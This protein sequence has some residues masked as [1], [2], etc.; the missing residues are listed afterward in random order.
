[1]ATTTVLTEEGTSNFAQAG[2]LNVHYNEAG[3]GDTVVMLHGGGPGASGWSNYVT[4]F[5][6]FSE[7]YRAILMDM[8]GYGKSDP[9]EMHE[10]YR[11]RINALAL[12]D[13]LDTLG[14][15]KANV[16]GNSMG[17]AT[18]A[19][20][21]IAYPERINKLVLMGAGGGGA[22][23]MQPMPLE[24][25][26]RI[27]ALFEDPTLEGFRE[28]IKIFVY[29]S[30]FMTDDLLHQRL[31]NTLAHPE[32]LEARRKSSKQLED[33]SPELSKIQADTLIVWGRD[34][35]FVPLDH[36]LKFLW[37]IP[38]SQLH[39]FSGCGHWAQY[40]KSGEFNTLVLDF[41]AR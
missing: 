38:K 18:A 32:H 1:M 4:N 24:G 6:P 41:L 21:A 13:L 3:T 19:T 30:S 22:S 5:G 39:V 2:N 31:A 20:F 16:I 37:S 11:N 28:L 8:P 29:D 34:D 33:L 26:K 35:R 17:G 10:D 7:H 40:E 12:R 27:A 15:E 23:I 9:K 25:I 14:I 36:A